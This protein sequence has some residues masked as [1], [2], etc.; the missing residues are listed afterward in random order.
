MTYPPYVYFRAEAGTYLMPGSTTICK[1]WPCTSAG[2]NN[3][4]SISEP[5]LMG[6]TTTN[7]ACRV[8]PY[9]NY[10]PA[11]HSTAAQGAF[12]NSK[13]F[14]IICAG[15]DGYYGG[16]GAVSSDGTATL[17]DSTASAPPRIPA[18]DNLIG[19][20]H[21]DNITNFSQGT[22]NDMIK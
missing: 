20:Q 11:K 13:H 6:A 16:A 15:L 2:F 19:G 14:Q 12:F 1:Y 7:M 3:G 5:T 8:R 4:G 10:D 21:F 18:V 9:Y 22:I 17:T